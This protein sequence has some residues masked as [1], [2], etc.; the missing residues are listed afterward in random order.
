M[1]EGFMQ[2]CD[3]DG[4]DVSIGPFEVFKRE[5]TYFAQKYKK[6]HSGSGDMTSQVT[7]SELQLIVSPYLFRNRLSHPFHSYRIDVVLIDA[8]C[9]ERLIDFQKYER[10]E[11]LRNRQS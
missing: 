6:S 9:D 5:T 1:P 2:R 8:A 3:S 11:K 4:K 10:N 7:R